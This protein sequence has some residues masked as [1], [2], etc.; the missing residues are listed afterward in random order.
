MSSSGSS[1]IKDVVIKGTRSSGEPGDTPTLEVSKTPASGAA[2][3]SLNAE[4]T[5]K[6][7]KAIS[8]DSGYQVVITENNVPLNNIST[9][10]LGQ[11]S[12]KVSHPNFIAGKTYKVTIPKELVKGTT[13]GRTP[14]N[15]ITWS[16]KTKSP[17]IG[18]KTPT[19][20]NMTFNGDP[21]TSIAFDWYTA[22]TVRGTVVQVVE[23]SN[24]G[25]SEFPEQ[26]AIS[27]EGSSTVIETLM[28]S[29]DRS[30]KKYKKFASHKVITSG[31]N[32]GT[33]YIYRAGNG[34]ADGWS[35]AGS[36]T[37][38]KADNQDFHFLYVTDTQGSSKSNFDLWQDTFKRAIEKTV[39][40]KFVLLTGDLTDD[41]DLEQL[42]QWF[43]GVP[44]KNLPMCHLHRLSATM[45]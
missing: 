41:G 7:N 23:A 17:D 12:V 39:D 31:L 38:D 10:L 22:E 34:D 9:S 40:P 37:T 21:K 8:L 11:D 26:L 24:V 28:T 30:S 15:D 29:G 20:L 42:W 16:F 2:D 14:E 35:E 5:V 3:V 44:K 25:G 27:Y 19:L 6:F 1:R 4:I 45:K 18:N 32:P 33:K 36:F 43:L 13:D